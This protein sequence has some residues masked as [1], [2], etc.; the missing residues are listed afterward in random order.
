MATL[1]EGRKAVACSRPLDP[2]STQSLTLSPR[3]T[4]SHHHTLS[5][6]HTLS[7]PH[8][9]TLSHHHTLLLSHHL[10]FSS[11]HSLSRL[12]LFS[13]TAPPLRWSW[14]VPFRSLLSGDVGAG[15]A[16]R[17]LRLGF[18]VQGLLPRPNKNALAFPSWGW[19]LQIKFRAT[20]IARRRIEELSK[21]QFFETSL[22][23]LVHQIC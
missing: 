13:P 18:G 9:L 17:A 5:R 6:H 15:G 8:P 21:R 7:L 1:A 16:D 22:V 10:T 19:V 3:H 11:S 20:F 23:Y 2:K 14:A 12:S 4:L